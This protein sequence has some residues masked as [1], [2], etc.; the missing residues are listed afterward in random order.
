MVL[1]ISRKIAAPPT[2]P[3]PLYSSG[4][5][6]IYVQTLWAKLGSSFPVL[7]L[8]I[9]SCATPVCETCAASSSMKPF[10]LCVGFLQIG[11]PPRLQMPALEIERQDLRNFGRGKN[12]LGHCSTL[13][14][15][16]MLCVIIVWISLCLA[17]SYMQIYWTSISMS[18]HLSD[19]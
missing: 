18:L 19:I 15:E 8:N 12:L 5:Q 1:L 10:L 13:S 7:R 4:A 2:H 6:P 3:I 11:P 17:H 14:R 9:F 16:K